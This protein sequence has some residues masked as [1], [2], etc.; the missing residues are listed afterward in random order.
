MWTG[1]DFASA[2]NGWILKGPAVANMVGGADTHLHI[3]WATELIFEEGRWFAGRQTALDE[4]QE[5]RARDGRCA[6]RPVDDAAPKDH[7]LGPPVLRQ[8]QMLDTR[9]WLSHPQRALRLSPPA[10]QTAA[11]SLWCDIAAF[12]RP[13]QRQGT[14][15]QQQNHSPPVWRP[16]LL[17]C[18]RHRHSPD[19]SR[20]PRST[21]L[22]CHHTPAQHRALLL[23][24]QLPARSRVPCAV[25]AAKVKS[26][27]QSGTCGCI[28]QNTAAPGLC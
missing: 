12:G 10:D 17:A 28:G 26:S 6:L 1:G 18:W 23:A 3:H 22:Y 7:V 9:K 24:L 11:V 19:C 8:S 25:S 5:Q 21:R 27:R 2:G 4:L 13:G 15:A 16:P 20:H 14:A